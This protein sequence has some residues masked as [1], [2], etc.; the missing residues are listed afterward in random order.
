MTSSV[1]DDPRLAILGTSD[2]SHLAQLIVCPSCEKALRFEKGKRVCCDAPNGPTLDDNIIRYSPVISSEEMTARDSQA[3]GYLDHGK[4]PTQVHRM[5]S[6][7]AGLRR[8]TQP[9]LNLGCGPGPTTKMLSEQGMEIVAV[10]FS[11]RSLALNKAR[12]ALFVQA[13]LNNIQFVPSSFDGLMMADFLQHLGGVA[14]QRQFLHTILS[15]LSPGGWFFL[16]CFNV[17]VKNRLRRDIDGSF[18]S[19]KI[20]YHRLTPSEVLEMLPATAQIESVRPMNIFNRPLYD[21][22][23]TRLPWAR[24]FARMMVIVGRKL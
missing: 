14:A 8:S 19:G 4:F 15:A 6:F 12:S 7:I 3:E 5:R 20:R 24:L 13:N 9:V 10:D 17:N 23:A 16:S 22:V 11:R 2:L 21:N 18:S 1:R